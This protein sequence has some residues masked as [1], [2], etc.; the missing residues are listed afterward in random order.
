MSSSFKGIS[1]SCLV[2]VYAIVDRWVLYLLDQILYTH[3]EC[4]LGLKIISRVDMSEEEEKELVSHKPDPV[5][6]Q[7]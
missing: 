2:G 7:R 1:R 6:S 3:V 4:K 5:L